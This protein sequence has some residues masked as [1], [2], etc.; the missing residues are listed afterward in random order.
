MGQMKAIVRVVFPFFKFLLH[1]KNLKYIALEKTYY[2][3]LFSS[4][5]APPSSPHHTLLW[6]PHTKSRVSDHT[7]MCG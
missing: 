6:G 5:G 3:G 7:E 4:L 1:Y 2:E